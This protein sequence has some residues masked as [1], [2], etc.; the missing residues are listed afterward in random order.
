M[1][2]HETMGVSTRN[3]LLPLWILVLSRIEPVVGFQLQKPSH[4]GFN[5]ESFGAHSFSTHRTGRTE[6]TSS[7]LWAAD[8]TSGMG[9]GWLEPIVEDPK[10]S[11]FFSLLMATCGAALGP[12]LDSYHSAFG[13]LKYDNPIIA[14]L[15]GT[16]KVPA[17]T[18]AWWVPELFGLAGFVI[19]WLYIIFDNALETQEEKT[20]PSPSKVFIGISIFTLQYWLSGILF[21]NQVDRSAILNLMSLIAAIGFVVFDGTMTGFI[22][23]TATGV[24]GPVIEVGLLWLASH[25]YL[26]GG[27]HYNDP[28]ETGF[29]PLWIIPVYFLGGPANGN[30]ARWVWNSLTKKKEIE[31]KACQVCND[32]R[33]DVCPNCGGIGTYVAMGGR[34]VN[35]TSCKGRGYCMC[36]ACFGR[37]DEDP[38]DIDAIRD[39]MSRMPD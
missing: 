35:C 4:L 22:A 31:K 12:F 33:R 7:K 34:S 3:F 36:R 20:D 25:G 30:L 23:S 5:H 16:D 2:A 39:V 32:T 15:W 1:V 11:L 13:V 6:P 14:T 10:R 9:S 37:Y 18:T 38:Y 24:G 21:Y 27:Y 26:A 17:L 19:G 29:F 8:D 28:G